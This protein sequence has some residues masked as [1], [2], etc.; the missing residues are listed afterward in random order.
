MKISYMLCTVTCLIGLFTARAHADVVI[1]GTRAIYPAQDRVVTVMLTNTQKT[2]PRLVQTW[3]DDGGADQAPEHLDVPFAITPPIF[4]MEAGKS[5]TLRIVYTKE[6][7]QHKKLPADKES[8]FWLN[9]LSVPPNEEGAEA[10]QALRFAVRTRIKLFFRPENLQGSADDSAQNLQWKLLKDGA[11]SALEVHNPGAYHVSFASIA[12][13]QDGKEVATETRP[14]L[15]PG[16]TER[17]VVKGLPAAPGAKAEVRY[18]TIDD[19]G[20]TVSHTVNDV[21]LSAGGQ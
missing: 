10:G 12:V 18:Q 2:Y 16:A 1:A 4:R 19:L 11:E 14:M 8:V 3:I 17:L 7:Q 6:D 21:A 13:A 15:A 9:V 20:Y 5:Q